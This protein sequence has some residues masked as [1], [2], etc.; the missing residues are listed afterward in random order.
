MNI[1]ITGHQ[2]LADA[3]SWRWIRTELDEILSQIP[4]PLVGITSLAI[5]ADQMFA[6]SVLGHDGTLYIVIP[7]H[8]YAMKFVEEQERNNYHRLLNMASKVEVLQK[9]ESDERGYYEAGKRVADLAD[10]QIAIWDGKPAGGLGGTADIVE[11]VRGT[12]KRLLHV[13]PISRT[14]TEI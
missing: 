14:V 11:Y 2:R 9:Q 5:G 3:S 10:L 6:E 8:G 1:G 7:F 4:R 12:G 13:N